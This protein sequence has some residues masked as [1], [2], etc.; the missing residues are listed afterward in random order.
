MS[1]PPPS[2][3]RP[4][5]GAS[6]QERQTE[7][8]ERLLAAAFDCFGTEGYHNTTMRLIC[9]KA[10]LAERYF[11][12][13][14]ESVHAA[15]VE[16]YAQSARQAAMSTLAAREANP[17]FNAFQK[18]EAGVRA[19]LEFIKND[20]RQAR[21]LLTDSITSGVANPLNLG[22][23]INAYVP[24]F[25]GRLRSRFPHLSADVNMEFIVGGLVGM[26]IHVAIIWA[27]QS[28]AEPVDKVLDHL[29]YAWRGLGLWLDEHNQPPDDV[30]LAKQKSGP[31]GPQ[32]EST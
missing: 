5:R 27:G 7:R 16:V 10:R 8:R 22:M 1:T 14:F 3:K 29:M 17:D 31:K 21:I 15:Y 18:S 30:G 12:E 13:S 23:H 32:E 9:A 28:F 4:Y 19:F 24:F 2:P 20:A 26:V 11:Y 6:A 25:R